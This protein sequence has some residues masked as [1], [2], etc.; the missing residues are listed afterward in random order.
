MYKLSICDVEFGNFQV[1]IQI[2]YFHRPK[3]VKIHGVLYSVNAVV[4][5][6]KCSQEIM[7]EDPHLY[8]LITSIY[9]IEDHKVFHCQ[10]L[11]LLEV[12]DH[13]KSLSVLKTN[14]TMLIT[15]HNFYTHGVLHLKSRNDKLY[16][17]E[18]DKM[19]LRL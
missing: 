3:A 19:C 2:I 1:K 17:V 9:V 10:V 14:R 5:V 12:V 11:E 7:T 4:W 18:K 15:Y 16:L 8:A 6:A 13:L